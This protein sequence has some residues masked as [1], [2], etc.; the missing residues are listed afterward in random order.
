[1]TP[2]QSDFDVAGAAQTLFSAITAGNWWVVAGVIIS[3]L[4]WLLLGPGAAKFPALA[5]VKAQPLF[6]FAVPIILSLASGIVA[7]AVSGQALT[8]PVV[9]AVVFGVLKTSGASMFAFLAATNGAEHAANAKAAGEAK[10]AEINSVEK[11]I[12]A[13]E[14][15]TKP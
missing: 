14:A 4:T 11:A 12:D 1:M 7:V 10:A 5:K 13:L 8:V 9:I 15:P 6:S 2:V 3:G